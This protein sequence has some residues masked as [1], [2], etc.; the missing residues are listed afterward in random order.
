MVKVFSFLD[1]FWIIDTLKL[2]TSTLIKFSQE[3]NIFNLE[4]EDFKQ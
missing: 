1:I 2:K 4:K 3:K